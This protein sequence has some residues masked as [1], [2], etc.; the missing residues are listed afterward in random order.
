MTTPQQLAANRANGA[1]STGPTTPEGKRR[2]SKNAVRH[3]LRSEPPVLPGERAEDWAEHRAGILR[4][5]AP[6]GTLEQ[7][8]ADRVALCLWRLRRAAAYETAVTAVGLEELEEPARAGDADPPSSPGQPEPDATPL[9]KVLKELEAKRQTVALEEDTSRLLEQL[10]ELAEDAPVGGDAVAGA[11]SEI[12]GELPGAD[13][14]YFDTSDKDF[15]AGLGLPGSALEAPYQWDGWTAG[16]VRQAIAEMARDFEA[17]PGEIL[18]KAV[19]SRREWD[20]QDKAEVRQLEARA[21]LLRRQARVRQDR[22]RR[23]RMLPEG[24]TLEKVCRYEAHLNRQMLQAL[25]E[26]QRLQAARAGEQVAPPAALDVT[27]DAAEG[28]SKLLPPPDPA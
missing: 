7:C 16:M 25:H 27:V 11:L 15:L 3:G 22:Q 5:L 10:P 28:A 2:S 20:E 1:R 26:L 21:K 12:N 24:K 23:R 14:R 8:L 13:E 18:A 9:R 19:A 6:A 4:S 17:D